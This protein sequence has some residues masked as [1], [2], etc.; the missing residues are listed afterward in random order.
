MA[1]FKKQCCSW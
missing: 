1:T